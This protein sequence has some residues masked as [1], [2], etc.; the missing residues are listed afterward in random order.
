V[1]AAEKRRTGSIRGLGRLGI[2]KIALEIVANPIRLPRYF[3][4]GFAKML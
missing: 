3:S 4:K 2:R 1:A